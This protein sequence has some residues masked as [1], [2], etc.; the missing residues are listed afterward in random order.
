MKKS[1]FRKRY[2]DNKEEV[3]VVKPKVEKTEKAEKA[4]KKTKRR[5][6]ELDD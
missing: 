2:A 4:E 6:L 1:V 5:I 3:K